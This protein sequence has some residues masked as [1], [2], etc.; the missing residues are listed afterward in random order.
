MSVAD[1]GTCWTILADRSERG[2]LP[3]YTCRPP[4]LI[5]A[6]KRSCLLLAPVH[7][8]NLLQAW[9]RPRALT[10]QP[11]ATTSTAATRGE[12][13][14]VVLNGSTKE[15]G[16]CHLR[17]PLICPCLF[18]PETPCMFHPAD[19]TLYFQIKKILHQRLLSVCHRLLLPAA[20]QPLP[21]GQSSLSTGDRDAPANADCLDAWDQAEQQHSTA[22]R[23]SQPEIGGTCR[24]STARF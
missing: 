24:W 15:E 17:Q 1:V 18:A 4:L 11:T 14:V 12:I 10:G 3:Y 6:P 8:N 5:L 7:S 23:Q 21:G 9:C 16:P 13:I 19:P 20:L 22:D 2:H